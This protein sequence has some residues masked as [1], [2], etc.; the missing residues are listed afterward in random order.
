MK[1]NLNARESALRVTFGLNVRVK[2]LRDVNAELNGVR[3]KAGTQVEA[4]LEDRIV[5]HNDSELDLSDLRRRARALGGRFQLKASKSEYL[6][7]NDPSHLQAEDILRLR[8]AGRPIRGH[9]SGPADHGRQ[10]SRA[11]DGAAQGRRYDSNR[12]RPGSALQL[13]GTHHRGRAQYHSHPRGQRSH[14]PFWQGR[15]WPGRNL[16]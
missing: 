3:L 5:F 8:S 16:I 6:V 1:C 10:Q 9:R 14:P 12:R 15:D 2:A 11:H 4:T 7:S 13:F